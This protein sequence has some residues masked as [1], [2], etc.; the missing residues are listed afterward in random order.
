MG[1]WQAW[2]ERME[3]CRLGYYIS[4]EENYQIEVEECLGMDCLP[5]FSYRMHYA[6]TKAGR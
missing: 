3:R 1:V 5:P 6:C 2:T 4:L